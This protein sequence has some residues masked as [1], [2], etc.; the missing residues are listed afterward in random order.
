MVDPDVDVRIAVTGMHLSPD[1]GYTYREI[2]NDGVK[3]DK[4]IETLISSTTSVSISKTMGLT[5]I[6][7]AEYF[8]ELNPTALL[9]LGDRYETLAVCC[10]A[11]NARIPIIHLHGGETT[12]GLIDEAVRHSITK[13][14]YLHLTSTEEYC[15][16]VIQLGEDPKRVFNVGALGVENVLNCVLL[17]REEVAKFL[18][19]PLEKPYSV[20]TYH[21]VTLE[22]QDIESQMYALFSALD[23]NENMIHIITKANADAGGRQ[24]NQML[25]DYSSSRKNVFLFDSLGLIR[26][27]SAVKYCEFVLGN[28]SSG[29]L[30]VPSLHVPTINIGDRQKGRIKA[31]SVIDCKGDKES[32]IK[33]IKKAKSAYFKDF[34]LTITNPY[35]GQRTS[36]TIVNLTKKYVLFNNVELK[37]KFY[38]L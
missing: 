15:K 10:A 11:M 34:C 30:E 6:S 31:E 26:Y 14:S 12:E 27:L 19:I 36:E 7:F 23:K 13:M 25:E 37:K 4:K 2:Q 8:E 22:S 1:F 24:I 5:M 33:A 35:E 16:R 17:T 29:L 28:S 3:I 18:G 9:V 20:I 32:I 38:D 21:P